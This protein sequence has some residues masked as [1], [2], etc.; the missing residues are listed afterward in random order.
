MTTYMCI[1]A[2]FLVA[3]TKHLTGATLKRKGLFWLTVESSMVERHGSRN[4]SRVYIASTVRKQ[5][6]PMPVLN[7]LAFYIV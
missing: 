4:S 3:L 6:K 2:S 5:R 1:L 7:T